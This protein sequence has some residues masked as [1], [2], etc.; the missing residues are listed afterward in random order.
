MA[1][2]SS[3]DPSGNYG[4]YLADLVV[5]VSVVSFVSLPVQAVSDKAA[6]RVSTVMIF[7]L[8][9]MIKSPFIYVIL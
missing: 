3:A 4:D 1:N 6:Q 5:C 2:K 9:F 8:V 7:F